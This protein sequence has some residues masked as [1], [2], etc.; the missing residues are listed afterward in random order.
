[1]MYMQTHVLALYCKILSV[2]FNSEVGWGKMRA[3]AFLEAYRMLG[4]LYT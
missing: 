1:M 3:L 2:L 4:A